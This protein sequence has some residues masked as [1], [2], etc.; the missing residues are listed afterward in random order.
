MVREP[1][2]QMNF[3]YSV[4]AIA[5][6]ATDGKRAGHNRRTPVEAMS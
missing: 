1:P 4:D 5:V 3:A 6:A 2:T